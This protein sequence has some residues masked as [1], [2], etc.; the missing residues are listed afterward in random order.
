MS[1]SQLQGGAHN[2]N[3]LCAM[4]KGGVFKAI[5]LA[6]YTDEGWRGR[7]PPEHGHLQEREPTGV[8]Q[9]REGCG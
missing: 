3:P 8:W 7:E 5:K 9:V 2:F 6:M 1:L 4:G